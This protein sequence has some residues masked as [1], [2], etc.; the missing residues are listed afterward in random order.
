MNMFFQKASQAIQQ[1]H[2]INNWRSFFFFKLVSYDHA[3]WNYETSSDSLCLFHFL[4]LKDKDL[5]T[6]GG[7]IREP[8]SHFLLACQIESSH[9]HNPQKF[10]R[11]CELEGRLC[12]FSLFVCIC[13]DKLWVWLKL[14][15]QLKFCVTRS[16][17]RGLL[18]LCQ[19]SRRKQADSP[20]KR[21]T[22]MSQYVKPQASPRAQTSDILPSKTN[23]TTHGI[24]FGCRSHRWPF[25]EATRAPSKVHNGSVTRVESSFE[26]PSWDRDATS[27]LKPWGPTERRF[28]W[29]D[30]QRK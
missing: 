26:R 20:F 1:C 11:V 16:W 23:R 14:W 18:A 25:S 5:S 2:S 24:Y 15:Q 28:L 4:W 10:R 3:P 13:H 7:H 17:A 9:Q 19:L 27:S 21:T 12:F 22:S 29:P 8:P 6:A 30:D